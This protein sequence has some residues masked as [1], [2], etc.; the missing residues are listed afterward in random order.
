MSLL[1]SIIHQFYTTQIAFHFILLSHV[2]IIFYH[3][4]QEISSPK[5]KTLEETILYYN[6]C[7]NCFLNKEDFIILLKW[8]HKYIFE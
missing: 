7:L 6:K 2:N 5:S 3:I 8:L 4:D 1:I